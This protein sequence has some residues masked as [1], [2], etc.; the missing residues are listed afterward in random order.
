[1]RRD[2]W[3]DIPQNISSGRQSG[4]SPSFPALMRQVVAYWRAFRKSFHG[5]VVNGDYRQAQRNLKALDL[6]VTFLSEVRDELVHTMETWRSV[7]GDSL[8][9]QLGLGEQ[10]GDWDLQ[11]GEPE[12]SPQAVDSEE[13]E[14]GETQQEASQEAAEAPEDS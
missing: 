7:N 5:G 2:I 14:H 13:E 4:R 6:S 8:V 1:M 10:L 3:L 12:V 11:W 9:A